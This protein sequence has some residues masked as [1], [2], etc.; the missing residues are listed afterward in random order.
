MPAPT[1]N[2]LLQKQGLPR[3][4][5]IKPEHIAP[6]VAQLLEESEKLF[7]NIEANAAPQW[8]AIFGPL[9]QMDQL[10][11]QTWKPIGHL[12]SV[13]N[14]P[15]LREAYEKALPGIVQFGLRV[16]QCRP[17]YDCVKAMKESG[18][19]D[20]F[21]SARKRI[22]DQ[23]LLSAKL[24]GIGLED[25]LKEQFNQN[26][27][28]LSQL[29]TKFSNNVLDSTKASSLTITDI[30]DTTGWPKSLLNLTSQ[31]FNMSS[32]E[33][34]PVSTPEKGPW[35]ITLDVPIIQPFGQHCQNRELRKQA[36]CV[37]ISRASVGQFDNTPLCANILQ[38][39]KEQSQLLG[40]S[41]YG[42]MSLAEK[43][44][45][46]VDAVLEMFDTLQNASQEPAKQDLIDIQKQAQENGFD[47]ELKHWDIAFWTERLREQRYEVTDET[48][49]QYFQHERVLEGLF[50]LVKRLFQV[51]VRPAD[52]EASLW[53]KDV[54]FFHIYDQGELIAGFYYDP[55]SRPENKRGGA[56]MD[57]C[58]NRRIT[59]NGLQIPIAYLICNCTPPIGD[60]PALMTFREVETL[61]HEFG[62]GLHHMLSEVD[63]PDVS[64]VNGV[65]WDAVELPSQFMENWCY[66]KPTLLGMTAHIETG[67]PLPDELFQKIVAARN[68]RAGSNTLRQLTL[69]II[70]MLLHTDYD[71]NGVV[72]VFEVQRQVME[73]TAVLPMLEQDRMLCSFQHIFAGGYA[74]GYYSYKW[75]EVLAADV[76]SAFEEAG[77]DNEQT[78]QQVGTKLRNT[79]FANGGSQHPMDLFK[80]FR[81]R[82]PSPEALLRQS[83][84]LNKP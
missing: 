59:E 75:A 9:D 46:S 17:V 3:F 81:G 68:F 30:A 82:E 66:H 36:Y 84:L 26:A 12:L 5:Q 21:S 51:E 79:I 14:S 15:E 18:D 80:E 35:K 69:G 32:K 4:D 10:F 63:E 64:G 62:H 38:L 37:Y 44:A 42:E 23:K 20:N 22:I 73:K 33:N 65:E 24:S 72:S 45:P 58:H 6:A 34:E 11:E 29:A 67:E 48:L 41:C 2:P 70:D 1:D 61:F 55:Y 54:R 49:R 40:Y 47:E 19:W 27:Q 7:N 74:A 57:E 78:I 43:M 8:D 52:G 71:P 13:N 25:G 28:K 83:G 16:R 77:L 53:N 31:T 56:W 39:R 50:D 60:Q 76:F